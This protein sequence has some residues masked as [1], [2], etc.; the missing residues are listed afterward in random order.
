MLNQS[1]ISE[2]LSIKEIVIIISRNY[3]YVVIFLSFNQWQI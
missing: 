2:R 3:M 1:L